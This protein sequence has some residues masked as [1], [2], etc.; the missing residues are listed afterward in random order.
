MSGRDRGEKETGK[1]PV[2]SCHTSPPKS[3]EHADLGPFP[4]GFSDAPELAELL[5]ELVCSWKR[6]KFGAEVG[7]RGGRG[8]A[9]V[10]VRQPRLRSREACCHSCRPLLSETPARAWAP[11]KWGS[12]RRWARRTLPA[13]TDTGPAALE[14]S[15][16]FLQL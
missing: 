6:C 13:R 4:A 2:S 14:A 15:P 7:D 9:E 8:D 12:L 1:A 11:S 3:R 10:S 5:P 16:P